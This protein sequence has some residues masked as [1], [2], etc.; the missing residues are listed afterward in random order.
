MPST[1]ETKPSSLHLSTTSTISSPKSLDSNEV[2]YELLPN[3]RKGKSDWREYRAIQLK[4]GVICVLVHD[5]ESK[6]TAMA[7]AVDAGASCDPRS[8]SGLAHFT[9][10]M[11][12]LGEIDLF[13]SHHNPFGTYFFI[14]FNFGHMKL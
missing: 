4:N 9:E 14:T 12:F 3:V 11:C 13:F 8:Y 5:K 1:I 2:E 6:Y 10:H 7:T